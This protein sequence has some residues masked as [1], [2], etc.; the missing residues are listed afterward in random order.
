MEV[1]NG[2]TGKGVFGEYLKLQEPRYETTG[3]KVKNLNAQ[4]N[5]SCQDSYQQEKD[6]KWNIA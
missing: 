3:W 6:G 5:W 2:R 1:K 4:V